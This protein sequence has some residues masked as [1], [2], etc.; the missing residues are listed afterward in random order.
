MIDM[1]MKFFLSL[2]VL[3]TLL[4]EANHAETLEVDFTFTL[5]LFEDGN[6]KDIVGH[7]VH[8]FEDGKLKRKVISADK[9]LVKFYCQANKEYK[10]VLVGNDDFV[11]KF[12]LIDTR[13]IDL[14]NWKYKSTSQVSLRYDVDVRLLRMNNPSCQ[15]FSFLKEEPCL[16]MRYDSEYDDLHDFATKELESK[17][18]AELKKKC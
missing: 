16:M 2:F 18:K 5:H 1:R 6:G 9:G 8:I 13:N 15:D 10:I 14:K 7:S 12:L 3:C 4:Q 11:E 17:I